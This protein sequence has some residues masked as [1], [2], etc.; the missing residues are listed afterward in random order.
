MSLFAYQPSS[1]SAILRARALALINHGNETNA[2]KSSTKKKFEKWLL[3]CGIKKRFL[4]LED[5]WW[6]FRA[7][8]NDMTTVVP[9][10]QEN[11]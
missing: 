8:N 4:C 5:G 3:L 1:I 2:R 7:A 6:W 10:S 11:Y 9:R